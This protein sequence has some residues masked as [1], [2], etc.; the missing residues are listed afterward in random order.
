MALLNC[1]L[2]HFFLGT[3]EDLAIRW[4]K[5]SLSDKEGKKL[6]LEKNKKQVDYVLAAKFLTKGMLVLMQWLEHFDLYGVRVMISIFVTRVTI[7]Y[8]LLLNLNL[9]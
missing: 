6:A 4:K 7:I 5:L 8:S 3:M 2:F 1:L 9:I